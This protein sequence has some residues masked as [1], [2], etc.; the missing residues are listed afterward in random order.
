MA[1][2]FL[3]WLSPRPGLQWLEIGCGTGALS[4]TILSH[5]SPASLLAV[6]PSPGFIEFAKREL[7]DPRITFQ[8][9]DALNLPVI[10]QSM[11]VAV[12]GLA[13]NFIREPVA[14]LQILR[15]TLRPGGVLAFYVWD[16]GGKMQMLR[17]FWDCAT[18]LDSDARS[19]DEALRFPMCRPDALMALCE[20][21]SLHNIEV[22]GIDTAMAFRDFD[23]Y[24]TPFLEGQGPAPGYVA[25]LDLAARKSLEACLRATLPFGADGT[26]N[27]VARA[28]AVRAAA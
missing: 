25:H 1:A 7:P 20:Q 21:A 12:S 13:L 5:E 9:G 27:L 26:L 3:E 18:A 17:Y 23:D 6:D 16:Y 2:A 19:L 11:D 4:A 8:V 15:G 28:W 24:W 10:P 14:V 22:T